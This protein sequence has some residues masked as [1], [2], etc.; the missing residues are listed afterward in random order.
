MKKEQR[1]KEILD[2]LQ[3]EATLSP[4][5]LSQRLYLSLSTVYR[6]IR[7]LESQKLLLRTADGKVAAPG[8]QRYI[9]APHKRNINKS[10]KIAIAEAAARLI[11]PGATIHLD[12]SSTTSYMID[13]LSGRQDITVL[14]P[15]IYIAKLLIAAHIPAYFSGGKMM[16]NSQV[17]GGR[18]HNLLLESMHVDYMF[19]SP[20]AISEKGII[21]DSAENSSR[22]NAL[23][24]ADYSVCLCDKSKFGGTSLFYAATVRDMDYLITDATLPETFAKPRIACI[25]V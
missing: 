14:T 2:A 10:A 17:L 25:T 3:L 19:F 9:P 15:S 23:T 8:A 22:R 21:F 18:I 1:Q 20:H 7:D 6:D 24:H 4:R 13:F 12:S 11:P 16:E 5:E